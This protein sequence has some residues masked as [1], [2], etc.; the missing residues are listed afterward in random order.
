MSLLAR[1]RRAAP[2]PLLPRGEAYARDGGVRRAGPDRYL[3]SIPGRAEGFEVWVDGEDWECSCGA[4]VGAC[5]HV[6]AVAV[7]LDGGLV[8][9]A[10][11]A[12]GV[13]YRLRRDPSGVVFDREVPA[14]A[15]RRSEDAEVNRV[16]A[17]WWGKPGVPRGLA[18]QA[19]GPLRGLDVT[20]DGAPVRCDDAPVLPLIVVQ[21]DPAGWRVRLVRRAGIDEAFPNGVLRMGDT[22][23][24]IGEADLDLALKQR[25]IQGVVFAPAEAARLVTEF[26][27]QLRKLLEVELR[28]VKLPIPRKDPPRIQW[29]VEADGPRLRAHARIV[30][31]EPPYARVDHGELRRLDPQ[32][33]PTRDVDAERRLLDAGVPIG[34]PIER[35][36]AA[37]VQWVGALPPPAR[38]AVLARAP[39][40]RLVNGG[41]EPVVRVVERGDGFAVELDGKA[42]ARALV[43][44]WRQRAP[45]VP[46]LGGGW[47]PVPRE[48][49][50]AHGAV[51][52]ELLDAEDEGGGRIGRG[53]AGLALQALDELGVA[54]P[55]ALA[56]LRA[57]TG[58]FTSIP[59]APL[60][61]HFVGALRPYQKR[62]VD[63]IHWLRSVG[64][65]GILADDM[66]LGKT[67]QC[68]AALGPGRHLVVAPT[69]VLGN[70][71]REA[72][73]FR[74]D[75]RVCR[76]HGPRRQLDAAADLVVTSWAVLRLDLERLR[77]G[78][79]TV[80]FDEA[81]A[82]KNPESQTAEAARAVQ[83]ELRLCVTGTPIENR[84]E[85]LWSGMHV[86]NPGLL[87]SR[88]SFRD[89]FSA[90]IEDGNKRARDD[91]RRRIRPFVLRRNK[92][93]VAPELPARTDVVL[94]C[95]LSERERGLY[96]AVRSLSVADARRML[97]GGKS[98][99]QV[100]EV[101]LRMRQAA[102]HPGL[103]PGG[104][105]DA[106]S[107]KL[108]L[109]TET[110]DEIVADGHR[111]LI[112][113]QWTSMLDLVE[114]ALRDAGWA[115]C[116][117]DG[118]TRDRDAEIARFAAP[119]GPPVFLLS[120]KAGGTGLNLTAADY[121]VH[122]DPW[123]NP[124]VEDQATD[125]AHRIG[126]TRPVVSLRLV[127]EDTVEERILALQERKRELVRAALDEDAL[128]RALSPDELAALF[129]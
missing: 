72:A 67:V 114:P 30:Y 60:P 74:P 97:E 73:R 70:W 3:V 59:S 90:P 129:A 121:V 28:T 120:L 22:L 93:D 14:G 109:L 113:S 12:L 108:A 38:D 105:H 6:V 13:R 45:L 26:L 17:G 82:I 64:M 31:G 34:V 88:R 87:G 8:Q 85:E 36:G 84:L 46:L 75:L 37:A 47:A 81:Q 116:R 1:V 16:L 124:A 52:A 110:L 103:L 128:A 25:L 56:A 107:A 127:A 5:A 79:T 117:L 98:Y 126:Q 43:E 68:L 51:L 63:W 77:T 19:L 29:D 89:R 86:A 35:E 58:D 18:Q 100:L 54:P 9:A 41:A 104:D 27:P 23:R 102:C 40:F 69:S 66:G 10:P 92:A 49:L 95:T 50:D 101:L 122:L 112:F 76:F 11:V 91:L 119:D 78:W 33:V 125:R 71:E 111:V 83:A 4:E 118:A 106:G 57:L 53:Q 65:G 2:P 80:L 20:L 32:V 42:D 21:D 24:P 94:K 55:P 61:A 39:G 96:D 62:G 99:L 123:W 44:A 48:W 7:A 15:P 115:Y